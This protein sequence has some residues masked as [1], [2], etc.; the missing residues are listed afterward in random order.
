VKDWRI[1]TGIRKRA[2][3]AL[4]LAMSLSLPAAAQQLHCG[5]ARLFRATGA[6]SL[7]P[8][9]AAKRGAAIEAFRT[10]E[11]AHFRI[12]Y[13]LA[14]LNRVKTV[15]GDSVLLRLADSLARIAPGHGTGSGD[16]AFI[17][18]RLD[19]MGAPHPRYAVEM[20]AYLE[21]A[22]AYYVDT[23][24]MLA[25]HSVGLSYYFQASAGNAGKYSVDIVDIGTVVTDFRGDPYYALTFPSAEG[26]MLI[27]N[28]FL[29]AA[30][31]DP[32]TGIPKGD[33][34]TSQYRG[35]LIH[36]YGIDWQAGLKVTCFHEFYHAVQFTYTPNPTN[37]H[38]WY[39]TGAVGMEE[40]N[41]PEVNDYLQYLPA[42]FQD[43]PGV[44][45][46]NYPDRLSWYGNGI[47]HLF[48]EQELG[49]GFD[50]AIW[51]HL[52]AN[53]N[54]IKDALSRLGSARGKSLPQVYA[55]F[56]AQLAFSGQPVRPPFLP[57]SPD[58]PLWPAIQTQALNVQP[59]NAYTTPGQ[60]PLTID[61]WKISGA[62]GSGKSA[63]VLDSGM[64][65]VL[66]FSGPDS[67]IAATFPGSSVRFDFADEAGRVNL[68]LL[69]N[70]STARTSSAQILV[71]QSVAS[72]RVFA[73]PNPLRTGP[74]DR[75]FFSRV[76][77]GSDIR[78]FSEGGLAVR[79]LSFSPDSALWSWDLKDGNGGLAK[80]GVY[81]YRENGGPLAPVLLY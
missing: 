65:P 11:T 71:L 9:L 34:I 2:L 4:M 59:P 49:E 58:M 45:M 62:A 23:L 54:N 32:A 6:K 78:I 72:D 56:A 47:F 43:L 60:L 80:P 51:S 50:V 70:G 38:V 13:T 52:A 28:D 29:Y 33:T 66:A 24:G 37:F 26:G 8:R 40:R 35:T 30:S 10:L 48:L 17:D 3:P 42:F 20:S 76:P 12:S 36:N 41:A 27:D 53:G 68:L 57:F 79:S 22:R 69:A 18:S 19:S 16:A 73:Y 64:V 61:A 67:N 14:G 21:Q 25:P 74:G 39:E 75:L 31:L 46:F 15:D 77:R 7:A 55:D 44:G 63:Q 1:G 81:Y 5:T